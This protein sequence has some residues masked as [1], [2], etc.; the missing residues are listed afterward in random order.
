MT[1]LCGGVMSS[2]SSKLTSG[3]TLAF[4]PRVTAQIVNT[5]TTCLLVRFNKRFGSDATM[6]PRTFAPISQLQQVIEHRCDDLLE[7]RALRA[8]FSPT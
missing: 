4:T 2:L 5:V 3:P 1:R 7:G 8:A 6:V